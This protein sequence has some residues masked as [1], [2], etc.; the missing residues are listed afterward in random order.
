MHARPAAKIAQ[1]A[2]TA[3]KNIW[4]SDGKNRADAASII[5]ILTLCAQKGSCIHIQA[6]SFEDTAVLEQIKSFFD[7]GFGELTE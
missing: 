5:D 3:Q 4:L 1:I 7:E 6:E 2:M